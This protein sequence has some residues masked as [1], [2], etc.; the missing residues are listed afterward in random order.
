M[1]KNR[2][3]KLFP[4]SKPLV[5][6]V[7]CLPLPGAPKYQGS[8]N[9]IVAF[10]RRQAKELEILGFDGIMVENYQDVPFYPGRVPSETVASLAVVVH[11]VVQAVQVP[12]GVNV[13]RNDGVSA[14]SIAAAT[15]ASFV[16]VN[17]HTGAMLGDQGWLLGEAHETMRKRAQLEPEIA[18]LADVLV[19][20][21]TPPPGIDLVQAAR[22]AASRGMADGL[23]VSG[24]GTG[25]ATDLAR[26]QA[27]KEAVP[28]TLVWIGSGLC[29]ENAA[30]SLEVAD[31]A[32]VGS[33]LMKGGKAGAGVDPERARAFLASLPGR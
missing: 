17:V 18:L 28:E 31:A 19:K 20:H 8:M 30:K 4:R 10:A 27:V 25:E 33:T 24:S 6:M 29:P 11:E 32:I 2:F 15:G 1:P 3:A 12:V 16:R 23:I 9:E 22:D 21:A 13:L 5:G 14:I 26:V 7:H